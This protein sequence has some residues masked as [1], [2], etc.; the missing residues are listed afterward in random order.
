MT[1]PTQQNAQTTAAPDIDDNQIIAERREKLRALRALL[2]T[3]P[4]CNATTPTRIKTRSKRIRS[5]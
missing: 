4:T 1:E 2:T 3:P 5:K